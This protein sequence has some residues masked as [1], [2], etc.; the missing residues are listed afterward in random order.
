VQ[1]FLR[2]TGLREYPAAREDRHDHICSNAMIAPGKIA[3][4]M[5]YAQ[6]VA[7]PVN[8]K[9]GVPLRL[10]VPVGGNPDRVAVVW[11]HANLGEVEAIGASL[12]AGAEYMRLLAANAQTFLPGA[13]HDELWMSI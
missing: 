12:L 5:A 6:Q 9:Y 11:S 7:K 8:D 1:A 3:E 4:A 10:N 13:T 2:L